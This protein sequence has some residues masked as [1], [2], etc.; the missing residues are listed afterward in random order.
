MDG[1]ARERVKDVEPTVSLQRCVK[2]AGYGSWRAIE[3]LTA[4]LLPWARPATCAMLHTHAEGGHRLCAS[5]MP[6]LKNKRSITRSRSLFMHYTRRGGRRFGQSLRVSVD[7]R[8]ER[9]RLTESQPAQPDAASAL[10]RVKVREARS[11]AQE[12]ASIGCACVCSLLG[13]VR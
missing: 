12:A 8:W 10:A 2:A 6:C 4:E 1:S 3:L 7:P 9:H 13:W 11:A 5:G